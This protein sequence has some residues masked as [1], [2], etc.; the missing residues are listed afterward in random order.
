MSVAQV[1][2][3]YSRLRSKR[4]PSKRDLEKLER[5]AAKVVRWPIK[6]DARMDAQKALEWARK[7]LT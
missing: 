4:A 6:E 5:L 2:Q 3:L 7:R 1:N